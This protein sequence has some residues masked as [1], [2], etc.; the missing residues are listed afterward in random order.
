[1]KEIIDALRKFNHDRDWDQF[2]NHKDLAL[3]LVLEAS[4]V[5]EHFQWKTLEQAESYAED[6]KDEIADEL[7]DVAIYMI[8][9]ADKMGIDILE[10]IKAKIAKNAAKYPVEK[11]KGSAKKY[12]EL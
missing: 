5:M 9:L 10:A 1:M 12:T 8:Q 6:H 11:S 2:H 3:S 7:A 4:E